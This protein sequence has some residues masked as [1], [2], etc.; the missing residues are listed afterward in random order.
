MTWKQSIHR[1]CP[2]FQDYKHQEHGILMESGSR[3]IY[4]M[5]GPG[6]SR[7]GEEQGAIDDQ[8][9]RRLGVGDD[10]GSAGTKHVGAIVGCAAGCGGATL[11]CDCTKTSCDC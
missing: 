3:L 1:R 10:S 6:Q 7:V 8:I 4:T 11:V 5:A 2:P 9:P